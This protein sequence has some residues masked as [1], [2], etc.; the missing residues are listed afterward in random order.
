MTNRP[1]IRSAIRRSRNFAAR[2]C[3]V[4]SIEGV[5]SIS[6]LVAALAAVL[7]IVH[8]MQ[9]LNRVEQ[10]AWA[11]ARANAVA[12]GPAATA[13]DL[14]TRIQ[15]VIYSEVGR[16][17]DPADFEVTV[18]A[19]TSPSNLASGTKSGKAS[20]T[21]GGDPNDLVFV[22]VR[23]NQ[24]A[25]RMFGRLLGGDVIESVSLARNEG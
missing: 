6:L 21:L 23:Y 9:T 2:A 25:S 19:Y 16:R 7:E 11:V 17:L 13:D 12:T 15:D 10:V 1:V 4:A 24:P 14:K 22:R 18:T 5:L 8:S 3:A 20:E